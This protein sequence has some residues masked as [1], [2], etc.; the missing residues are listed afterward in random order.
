M[1]LEAGDCTAVGQPIYLRRTG[2]RPL[3]RKT[4]QP[5]LLARKE[6]TGGGMEVCVGIQ[7]S[8]LR[9]DRFLA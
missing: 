5:G 4:R 1:V 6:I 8:I 3:A 7:Q 2:H 9:G